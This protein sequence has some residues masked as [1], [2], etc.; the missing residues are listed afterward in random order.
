MNKEKYPDKFLMI[1]FIYMIALVFGFYFIISSI[2]FGLFI[3][4]DFY[5]ILFIIILPLI[6]LILYHFIP[7]IRFLWGKEKI[8]RTIIYV[9]LFIAIIFISIFLIPIM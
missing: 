7:R 8:I 3:Y 5:L 1:L 9:F 6:L 4:T 2:T